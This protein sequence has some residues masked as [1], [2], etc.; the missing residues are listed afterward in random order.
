MYVYSFNV[1][2]R[3]ED[4]SFLVTV[5]LTLSTLEAWR[6]IPLQEIREKEKKTKSQ[7]M[8]YPNE[9]WKRPRLEG[10][11]SSRLL[12][13]R[14]SRMWLR[15]VLSKNAWHLRNLLIA[16]YLMIKLF[17]TV[18]VAFICALFF[19]Y[20]SWHFFAFFFFFFFLEVIVTSL[21]SLIIVELVILFEERTIRTCIWN[22]PVHVS[23]RWIDEWS[24]LLYE[25]NNISILLLFHASSYF[26]TTLH[27]V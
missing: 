9:R 19:L 21:F 8:Y 12:I 22:Y 6:W 23:F 14:R 24:L 16:M 5:V 1:P 3:I 25:Y 10:G 20:Y 18:P 17:F 7:R 2:V 11:W 26:R 27:H 13:D 15:S 4:S